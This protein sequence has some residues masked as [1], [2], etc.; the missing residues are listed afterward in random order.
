MGCREV[1]QTLWETTCIVSG[2]VYNMAIHGISEGSIEI[3]NPVSSQLAGFRF[4]I[5]LIIA[6]RSH[7]A[8]CFDLLFLTIDLVIQPAKCGSGND[9]NDFL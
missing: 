8:Q 1:E 2:V 3:R 6:L 7:A 9:T 5:L 4:L